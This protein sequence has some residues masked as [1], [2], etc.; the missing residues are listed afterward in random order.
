MGSEIHAFVEW[1]VD[2]DFERADHVYSL[3]SGRLMLGKDYELFG[4]MAGV[5]DNESALYLSLI[6][7]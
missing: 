7:I 6:H 3:S 4:L 1:I 2:D 5:R